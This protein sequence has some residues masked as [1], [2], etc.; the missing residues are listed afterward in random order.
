MRIIR[1]LIYLILILSITGLIPA[2]LAALVIKY[3]LLAILVGIL[4]IATILYEISQ[5]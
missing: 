4:V 2:L 3:D 1:G 5:M